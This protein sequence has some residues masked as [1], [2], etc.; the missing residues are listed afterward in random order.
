M[1]AAVIIQRDDGSVVMCAV[2]NADSVSIKPEQVKYCGEIGSRHSY[3]ARSLFE[4]IEDFFK[5]EA[6]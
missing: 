6:K 2:V 3:T 1:K 4:S 5:V